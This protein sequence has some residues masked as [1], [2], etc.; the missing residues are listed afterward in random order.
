M[1]ELAERV[2]DG[3]SNATDDNIRELASWALLQRREAEIERVAR[4]AAETAQKRAE[5]ELAQR[6][7]DTATGPSQQLMSA[8]TLMSAESTPEWLDI[9]RREGCL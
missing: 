5:W 3:Y 9:L 8:A 6:D 2:A 7:L 1:L 4:H